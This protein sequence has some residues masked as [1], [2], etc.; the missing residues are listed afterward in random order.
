MV[1]A[2][3]VPILRGRTLLYPMSLVCVRN[4]IYT[5]FVSSDYPFLVYLLGNRQ[6]LTKVLS[7][8]D[9]SVDKNPVIRSVVLKLLLKYR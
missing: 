3:T 4:H 1:E 6:M 8:F 7:P 5:G 9:D 2:P